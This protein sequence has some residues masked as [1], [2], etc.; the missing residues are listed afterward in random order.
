MSPT[1]TKAACD[2]AADEAARNAWGIAADMA[3][4]RMH[5]ELIERHQAR[6]AEAFARIDAIN[7]QCTA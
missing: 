3:F 2:K 6:Q 1:R 7:A 5:I 4:N